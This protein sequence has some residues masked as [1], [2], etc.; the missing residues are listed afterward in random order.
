MKSESTQFSD[1]VFKFMDEFFLQEAQ[2]PFLSS[3]TCQKE[4]WEI[5][6]ACEHFDEPEEGCRACGCY[7]PHKIKDPWGD[8]PFDKWISNDEEW[9][10][11]HYNQ[12]KEI[13]IEKY[14]DYE[15][16]IGQ[17]ETKG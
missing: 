14:P 4:R 7:L 15:H 3:S 16:I 10:N 12:L 8:C 13:I 2:M 5:C 1:L 11:T 9:K 17:Y 6:Q